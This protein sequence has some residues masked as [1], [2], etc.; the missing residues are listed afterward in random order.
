MDFQDQ[1]VAKNVENIYL[2]YEQKVSSIKGTVKTLNIILLLLNC[3]M[4]TFAFA[5]LDSKVA[6]CALILQIKGIFGFLLQEMTLDYSPWFVSCNGMFSSIWQNGLGQC[7]LKEKYHTDL[8]HFETQNQFSVKKTQE[9]QTIAS[10]DKIIT[11]N[12]CRLVPLAR[13]RV[14][15]NGLKLVRLPFFKFSKFLLPK[16]TKIK[17]ELFLSRIMRISFLSLFRIEAKWSSCFTI[18]N[19]TGEN[20]SPFSN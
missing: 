1:F 19:Q 3:N 16:G 11:P 7:F 13:D 6:W 9:N 14:D 15:G 20:T 17:Q 10:F 12:S 5:I 4:G 18:F 8:C 2:K